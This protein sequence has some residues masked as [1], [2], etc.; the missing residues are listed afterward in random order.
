MLHVSTNIAFNIPNTEVAKQV[1]SE[2][3]PFKSVKHA[4]Q[5]EEIK[6]I[7]RS[8]ISYIIKRRYNKFTT[9]ALRY[10]TPYP[11]S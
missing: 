6:K 1:S 2:I 9:T 3:D 10:D 4:L 11:G 7:S 8:T 5:G